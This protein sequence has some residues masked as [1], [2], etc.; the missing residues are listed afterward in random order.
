[1]DFKTYVEEFQ[2]AADRLDEGLLVKKQVEVAVGT[3]LSSV[4]IK[5]YKKSWTSSFEDLLTAQSRIFFSVWIN[6]RGIQEHKLFYNIHA[7]KLRHLPGYCIQS[8]KFA[9]CFRNSFKDFEHKWP[10]V[11]V[12]FGPLTLMQGWVK[13]DLGNYQEEIIELADNFLAIE[14]LV[15][16]T[17]NHFK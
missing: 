1:M 12:Q 4:F 2:Q 11:S 7:F 6:D 17:L 8:R 14:Y 10:N 16:E 13:I 3:V 9:E 15:D 5:L